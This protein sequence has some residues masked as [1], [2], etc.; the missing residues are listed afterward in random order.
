MRYRQSAV[1]IYDMPP[2]TR[3]TRRLMLLSGVV[4]VFV[5]VGL[6]AL[7]WFGII[8]QRL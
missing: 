2:A 7:A 3:W 1:W 8:V 5:L 6:L 4:G